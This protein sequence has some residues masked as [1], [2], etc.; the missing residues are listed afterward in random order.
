MAALY[1]QTKSLLLPFLNLAAQIRCPENCYTDLKSALDQ[2]L[3][4]EAD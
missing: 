3:T 2:P 4:P 1:F